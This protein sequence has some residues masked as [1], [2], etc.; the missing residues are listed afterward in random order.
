M[1]STFTVLYST[2][3]PSRHPLPSSSDH[4]EGV[5]GAERP[6]WEGVVREGVVGVERPMWIGKM[7]ARGGKWVLEE[8]GRKAGEF[9]FVVIAHNDPHTSRNPPT[10]PSSIPP[11]YSP[12]SDISQPPPL[13]LQPPPFFTT[14]QR[15]ELSSIWA[16]I[17]AFE[18]P[19]LANGSVPRGHFDA[20][21]VE[22]VPAVAWMCNNTAKLAEGGGAGRGDGGEGSGVVR[23][24]EGVEC[25]TVFSSAA[26]GK[27]NK[28]PQ[29]GG[30]DSFESTKEN[31]PLA[32]A[33][34]VKEEMLDGV[35][36]ALGRPKDS[37]PAV[38]FHKIQLWGAALPLN[39]PT[40]AAGGGVECI[41]DASTRVGLCGDWLLA[42][43]VQAAAI[44]GLAMADKI[45]AFHEDA[46]GSD[47]A[48]FSVGLDASF[49]AVADAHDI[50]AFPDAMAAESNGSTRGVVA[51]HGVQVA[52]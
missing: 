43:S 33:A 9:D 38:L 22:G 25:W 18:S 40:T 13:P 39:A 42:P 29:V 45:A 2:P 7:R 32:R 10:S 1:S 41:M 47:P 12:P 49:A 20:A 35:A 6:V 52:A 28:V 5:V 21:F 31:I 24:G 46:A 48:L 19:L 14:S 3:P 44:S 17:I 27:R 15:L 8:T 11:S 36:A 30:R 16:S 23:R 34:R 26:Y 51:A 37:L 4:R 50:G